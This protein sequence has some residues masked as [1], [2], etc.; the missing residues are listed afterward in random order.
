[1]L[2]VINKSSGGFRGGALGAKAPP[3]QS[4]LAFKCTNVMRMDKNILYSQK[5]AWI[6]G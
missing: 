4:P 6:R 3:F 2:F 5:V 1:M